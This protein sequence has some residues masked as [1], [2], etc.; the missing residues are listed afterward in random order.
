MDDK[1]QN[2][3][4][5]S[6]AHEIGHL[7]LHKNIYKE[8]RI[9]TYSDFYTFIEDVPRLEYGH[10]ETQANKFAGY[11]LMP[12]KMLEKERNKLL[13]VLPSDIR[14]LSLDVINPYLLTPLS[15]VFGVSEQSIEIALYDLNI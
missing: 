10:L 5:F 6:L 7:V 1:Y 4:R 3:L 14:N 13:S 12:R 9:S 15:C 2:R 8:F 11:A